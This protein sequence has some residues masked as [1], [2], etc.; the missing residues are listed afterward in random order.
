M[1]W[2]GVWLGHDVGVGVGVGVSV[3]V[4]VFLGVIYELRL[5]DDDGKGNSGRT[6]TATM[7]R[8]LG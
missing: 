4:S 1:V 6:N 2:V 5:A 7:I 8:K 3:S